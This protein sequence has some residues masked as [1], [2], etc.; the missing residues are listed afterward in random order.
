MPPPGLI[1]VLR[2]SLNSSH[3]KGNTLKAA[4]CYDRAV[5]IAT[6]LWDLGWGCGCVIVSEAVHPSP[7]SRMPGRYRNFLMACTA[8][9]DQQIQPMYPTLLDGPPAPG[10]RNLQDL[11]EEAWANGTVTSV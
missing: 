8:L 9:M 2:R 11:I 4:L 3:A 6:Q 7:V 1:P 5:H 10:V